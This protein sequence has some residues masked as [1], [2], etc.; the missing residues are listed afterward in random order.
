MR[1]AL[2]L[3]LCLLAS[4]AAAAITSAR[5]IEPTARYQHGVFGDTEE[6]GALEMRADG[7]RIVVRLPASRVFEDNTPRLVDVDGDGSP[8]VVVIE[9]DIA[10][11]AQLAIYDQTGKIAATPPIGHTHRWLAPVGAADLDGDGLIELAY[12]DRPHLARLLKVWRFRA[13]SLEFVAALGGLTN[14]RFGDAHISG[15]IRACGGKPE[16]VTA[17]ADWSRLM[18][19]RLIGGKLVA[20]DIGA[21]TGPES[22]KRA[23]ACRN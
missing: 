8:E 10:R 9:T 11:G 7:K 14:H 12:V 15:G 6:W 3:M 4:P 21:N 17:N 16:M 13:N 20:R 19:T 23:L 2:A 22:F 18:A 5:F 1:G